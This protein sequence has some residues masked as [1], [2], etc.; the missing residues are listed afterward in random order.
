MGERDGDRPKKS[1]RDIDSRR[2]RSSSTPPSSTRSSS[3]SNGSSG[4]R[5]DD[6]P[7]RSAADT[8]SKQYRAAL[9]ALFEKGGV[10]KI[11]DKLGASSLAPV[12]TQ[13]PP[14]GTPATVA[15]PSRATPTV[16]AADTARQALRRKLVEA[17]GRDAITR[18]AD[19]YLKDHTLPEDFE[20]LEQLLEHR[21]DDRVSQTI[22]RLDAMLAKER[23]KRSR[24]MAAKLRMIEETS[25]NRELCARAAATRARLG[26]PS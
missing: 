11:A 18:A 7:P 5:R 9:E 8:A 24:V 4:S 26:T 6:G 2:D 1:W 10:A 23:P 12:S 21:D 15:A 25:D 19:K 13:T 20:L 14:V 22:D 17:I 16:P 3:G